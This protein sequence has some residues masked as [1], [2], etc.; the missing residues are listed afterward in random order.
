MSEIRKFDK[1]LI[2]REEVRNINLYAWWTT[3]KPL[4]PQGVNEPTILNRQKACSI[5]LLTFDF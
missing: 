3:P 1:V 5:L 2:W 4:V